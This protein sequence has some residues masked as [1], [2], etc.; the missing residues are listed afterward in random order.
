MIKN[1]TSRHSSQCQSAQNTQAKRHVEQ[2][3]TCVDRTDHCSEW[4]AFMTEPL[5]HRHRVSDKRLRTTIHDHNH[6]H[7]H[8]RELLAVYTNT[9]W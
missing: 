6:N 4:R 8:N 5:D 2:S 7:N 3:E 9:D 1:N